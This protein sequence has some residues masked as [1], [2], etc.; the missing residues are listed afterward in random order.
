MEGAGAVTGGPEPEPPPPPGHAALGPLANGRGGG[1]AEGRGGALPALPLGPPGVA[2]PAV[3][4]PPLKLVLRVL[5]A[6]AFRAAAPLAPAS[7]PAAGA[8]PPPTKLA[9]FCGRGGV[10]AEGPELDAYAVEE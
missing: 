10:G 6:R 4:E 7:V 5:E 2:P 1:W 3:A 8:P 9:D